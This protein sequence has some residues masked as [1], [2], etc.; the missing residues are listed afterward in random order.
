[1]ISENKY[2]INK[3][4]LFFKLRNSKNYIIW[5]KKG[6]HN[7]YFLKKEYID[8]L[9][10]IKDKE[11]TLNEIENKYRLFKKEIQALIDGGFIVESNNKEYNIKISNK[12]NYL[13]LENFAYISRT[14]IYAKFEL[15]YNCNFSCKYCFVKRLSTK[16]IDLEEVK[17]ILKQLKDIGVV[18]LFLTGGEP[19]LHPDIKEILKYSSKLGFIT[20]LQTNGY[21]I[22]E[23][24][25]KF[26]ESLEHFELT[27]SYHSLNKERF[28]NFTNF[29]GSYEKINKLINILK[30]T[31]IY[32]YLKIPI[33]NL[34][35]DEAIIMGEY[36]SNKNIKFEM[37]TQILPDIK[38]SISTENF[39]ITNKKIIKELYNRGFLVFQ[40][41][42]C[43]ALRSK[44][45]INPE[46]DLYPCELYRFK[47]GN[48][49]KSS[50]N[51]LWE[52]S[53]SMKVLKSRIYQIPES[54]KSCQYEEYCNRCL[55][56]DFYENWNKKLLYFCNNAKI[57]SEINQ[58]SKVQ[59]G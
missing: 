56:Y 8:F 59:E 45:W 28:D 32:F 21:L 39:Q 14:P 38:D 26:F 7:I 53:L 55:A 41:S 48:L 35:V 23:K 20:T 40:K 2:K 47:I 49:T 13:K 51:D 44:L 43:S 11:F 15:T 4:L 50:I 3:N 33:T 10:K 24:L 6:I 27:F 22:D 16:K 30:D 12:N 37:S 31:N 18:Y 54:C 46:G 52:N 58:N 9:I 17:K 36:F 5:D 1:M 42:R 34:N 25:I 19:L 57:I 29:N